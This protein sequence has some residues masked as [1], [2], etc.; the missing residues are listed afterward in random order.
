MEN[1]IN[2]Q[3]L[4]G[5]HSLI[6]IKDSYGRSYSEF[7]KSLSINVLELAKNILLPVIMVLLG[8]LAF[9]YI[10]GYFFLGLFFFIPLTMWIS[11]WKSAYKI[12]FHEA[13]HFN[14]SGNKKIND[15]IANIFFAPFTGM[16]I[17][18]YRQSHWKHH[19]FLGTFEDTEISYQKPITAKEFIKKLTG[20]YLLLTVLR[21]FHNF[22]LNKSSLTT[23]KNSNY[24]F[25]QS[26]ALLLFTQAV[27]IL[28][29]LQYTS[30]LSA[31]SW[32]ASVFFI[33]P[34]L[35]GIR[36]TLEHRSVNASKNIDYSK[37]VHG[38]INKIFGSGFFSK[39][40]GGAGFNK[41]LLHHFDPSISYTEF[42]KLETFLLDT[43][44]KDVIKKNT[45]TYFKTFKEIIFQ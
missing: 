39:Y 38:P 32:F 33:D 45:S 4:S 14:L 31:V 18:D 22:N 30:T 27:I 35:S 8:I 17:K 1:K 11:F 21:Y 36:Q 19:K 7:K 15:L 12:H 25:I 44:L 40:F 42:N 10:D 2:A 41:H 24:S 29:L 3:D 23:K 28:L 26:I 34:L 43:S 5:V 37:H 6:E 9:Y 16:W 13:A 20:I